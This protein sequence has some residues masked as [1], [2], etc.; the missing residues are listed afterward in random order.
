MTHKKTGTVASTNMQKTVIVS[1][2]SRMRHPFYKKVVRSNKK[3]KA[4]C[5]IDVV[6]G[7]LV[8]IMET[9]PISKEVRFKV[10]SKV[11]KK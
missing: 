9:R 2:E 8:E 6:V 10:I 11:D 1:V 3:F 7:D 4:H 5:E